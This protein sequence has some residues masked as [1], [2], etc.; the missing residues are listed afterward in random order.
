MGAVEAG[1]ALLHCCN[2]MTGDSPAPELVHFYQSCRAS[3]R[4]L[5]A[6]RHLLDEKFHR[7]P[8]WIRR[9]CNYLQLADEHIHR[10]I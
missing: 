6:A 5:L 1:M 10:C 4:A 3:R 8:D 9:A 2:R 7:S